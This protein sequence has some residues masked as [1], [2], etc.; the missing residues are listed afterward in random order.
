[1]DDKE[2]RAAPS[3]CAGTTPARR[4][5]CRRRGATSESRRRPVRLAAWVEDDVYGFRKNDLGY[6]LGTLV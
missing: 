3:M 5:A 1:M 2:E 4:G 6:Q